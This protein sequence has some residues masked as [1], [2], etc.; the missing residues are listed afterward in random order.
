MWFGQISALL[1]EAQA[2]YFLFLTSVLIGSIM[3]LALYFL[4]LVGFIVP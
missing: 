1:L 2:S 3:G 4:G